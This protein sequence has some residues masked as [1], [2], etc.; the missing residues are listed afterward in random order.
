MDPLNFFDFPVQNDSIRKK[1]QKKNRNFLCLG[2]ITAPPTF[3][4]FD[5]YLENQIFAGH[6]VF[7]ERSRT[8]CFNF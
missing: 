1:M 7:A 5:P 3:P 8:I 4:R 2:T 6:A